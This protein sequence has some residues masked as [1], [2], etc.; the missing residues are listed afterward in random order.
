[1][2]MR[3]VNIN[4]NWF[5]SC[6]NLMLAAQWCICFWSNV[7]FFLLSFGSY[8]IKYIEKYKNFLFAVH[9][10]FASV[11]PL[12][13]LVASSHT[14]KQRNTMF[15]QG[16]CVRNTMRHSIEGGSA[17]RTTVIEQC[18]IFNN[19]SCLVIYPH[20]RVLCLFGLM[21]QAKLSGS[22]TLVHYQNI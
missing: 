15:N 22:W 8:F 6:T 2:A 4:G 11:F 10:S 18:I 16:H 7:L 9:R 13:K 20:Q 1:M 12:H 21:E 3:H 19:S 5:S 17:L 14:N